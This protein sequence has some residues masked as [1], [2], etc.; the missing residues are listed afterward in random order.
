MSRQNNFFGAR[1]VGQKNNVKMSQ[2][3]GPLTFDEAKNVQFFLCLQTTKSCN[4]TLLESVLQIIFF[5]RFRKVKNW[6]FKKANFVHLRK[7]NLKFDSQLAS[8]LAHN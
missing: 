2:Q 7:S 8:A 5:S 1:D 4:V 6:N 3:L